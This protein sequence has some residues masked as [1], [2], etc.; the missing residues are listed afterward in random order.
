MARDTLDTLDEID[1]YQRDLVPLGT[2]L[3]PVRTEYSVTRWD[4]IDGV[5]VR[6]RWVKKMA[7][8]A[9]S[10]SRLDRND[11][12]PRVL[13]C[14]PVHATETRY[15]YSSQTG[16]SIAEVRYALPDE[17]VPSPHVP[18]S[19]LSGGSPL[20]RPLGAIGRGDSME[21]YS[22]GAAGPDSPAMGMGG[23]GC[24]SLEDYSNSSVFAFD[25]DDES[26]GGSDDDEDEEDDDNSGLTDDDDHDD[27]DDNN[28]GDD[29]LGNGDPFLRPSSSST[30]LS[31]SFE[32]ELGDMMLAFG[33]G[34][35]IGGGL[36]GGMDL[37]FGFES[38]PPR[39]RPVTGSLSSETST[40][41]GTSP[42]SAS[43]AFGP[44]G[45][46]SNRQTT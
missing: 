46:A 23:K 12:E 7:D 31:N 42:G 17:L 26:G 3:R 1:I 24:D 2:P 30:R 32:E 8:I 4:A 13:N 37:G 14:L 20:P 27:D 28:D 41:S 38:S 16:G 19:F 35:G 33:G 40:G 22:K 34:G 43:P 21:F 11:S 10:R 18:S 29:A 36:L 44:M 45:A 9:K 5:P 6:L 15:V 25:E 39:R